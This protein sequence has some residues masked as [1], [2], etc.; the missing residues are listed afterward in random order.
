MLVRAH[1][2]FD[3]AVLVVCDFRTDARL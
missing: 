3:Q 1:A 2:L